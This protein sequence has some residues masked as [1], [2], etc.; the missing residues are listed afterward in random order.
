MAQVP[1]VL[2]FLDFSQVNFVGK[3]YKQLM[4]Y[5]IPFDEFQFSWRSSS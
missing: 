3:D 1:C 4:F 2:L 5:L